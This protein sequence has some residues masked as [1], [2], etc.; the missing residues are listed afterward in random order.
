MRGA[1]R[2]AFTDVSKGPEGRQEVARNEIVS[3]PIQSMNCKL[4]IH[5]NHTHKIASPTLRYATNRSS[6]VR[7]AKNVKTPQAIGVTSTGA[8][9]QEK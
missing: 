1:L 9:Y 8:A 7:Y 5:A 6:V 2:L 4:P 3:R